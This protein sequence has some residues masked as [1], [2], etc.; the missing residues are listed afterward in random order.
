M[1]LTI[2]DTLFKK[3]IPDAGAKNN[4][5]RKYRQSHR[6]SNPICLLMTD[7]SDHAIYV[8][9]PCALLLRHS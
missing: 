5:D 8:D 1:M 9:D 4:G 3:Y 7:F 6:L 2:L